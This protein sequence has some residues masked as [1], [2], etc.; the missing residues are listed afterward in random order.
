[1]LLEPAEAAASVLDGLAIG[2]EGEADVG[3]DELVGALMAVGHAAVVVRETHFEGGNAD[4]LEPFA[5]SPL[6]VPLGVPIGE[7]ED[8]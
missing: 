5:Q 4:A 6:A 2:L 8:S 1:M 7:D 3:A